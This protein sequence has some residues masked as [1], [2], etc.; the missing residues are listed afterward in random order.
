MNKISDKYTIEERSLQWTDRE[1]KDY[2]K[3]LLFNN[4]LISINL[5][6]YYGQSPKVKILK[7]ST[8]NNIYFRE[9]TW[10]ILTEGFVFSPVA[11]V[12]LRVN[13]SESKIDVQSMMPLE[14]LVNMNG[15][16]YDLAIEEIV[17][18]SKKSDCHKYLSPPCHGRLVKFLRKGKMIAELIEFVSLIPNETRGTN[19]L[20]YINPLEKNGN[21]PTQAT[22]DLIQHLNEILEFDPQEIISFLLLSLP[23]KARAEIAADIEG[24]EHVGFMASPEL[25]IQKILQ[26]AEANGFNLQQL[27]FPSAVFSKELGT[28]THKPEVDTTIVRAWGKSKTGNRIG[29]EVFVPDENPKIVKR[30]IHQGR[31]SHIALRVVSEKALFR[32][33]KILMKYGIEIPAFM[34]NQPMRNLTENSILLYADVIAKQHHLRIEFYHNYFKKA[35]A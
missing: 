19:A 11:L 20:E 4:E 17:D 16:D 35:A 32:I 31:G 12:F 1:L 23:E 33:R 30:W 14:D 22:E 13:L 29:L 3:S 7:E 27:T 5:E 34:N 8:E 24:I 25:N 26:L 9:Y 21:P 15:E 28:L 18:P 10:N 6:K 2:P